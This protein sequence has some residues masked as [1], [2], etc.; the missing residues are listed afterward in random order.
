MLRRIQMTSQKEMR[1][2]NKLVDIIMKEGVISKVQL[3]L[4]SS[5]S[6]SYYE[7]LKP[8][9]EEIYPHKIQYD[10]IAKVWRAIKQEDV[11]LE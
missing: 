2:I 3:V 9:M 7:K 4:S 8:F 6:I 11:T 5:I 10:N 1:K